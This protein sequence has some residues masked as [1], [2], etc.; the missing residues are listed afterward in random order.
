MRKK[1]RKTTRTRTTRKKNNYQQRHEHPRISEMDHVKAKNYFSKIPNPITAYVKGST[2]RQYN[3]K[4]VDFLDNG[5]G[6]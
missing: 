3:F 6:E 4:I 2:L 1:K 5:Y